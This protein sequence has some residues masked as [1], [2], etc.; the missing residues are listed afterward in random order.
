V[1]RVEGFSRHLLL[2]QPEKPRTA[3]AAVKVQAGGFV[4]DMEIGITVQNR[5]HRLIIQEQGQ[6]HE[7]DQRGKEC[8]G[9]SVPGVLEFR[10][11]GCLWITVLKI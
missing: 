1:D 3:V 7:R 11:G 2:Q 8:F 10:I 5:N 9:Q 4:K 6:E